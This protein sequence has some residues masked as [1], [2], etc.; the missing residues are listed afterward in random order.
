MDRGHV[1]LTFDHPNSSIY[2]TAFPITDEFGYSALLSVVTDRV[3]PTM[4]DLLGL[5]ELRKLQA[6]GWEIGSHSMTKHPDFMDLST[7][8][9]RRQ[10]QGS[11]EW[12]AKH[13]F[14]T[15][16]PAI[17]YPME[18]VNEAVANITE[19]Y[20]ATGFGG[21]RDLGAPITNPL[22]IGRVNG[23]DVEATRN[24]IDEAAEQNR[25]LSIMYHTVGLDNDRIGTSEFERTLEHIQ[26]KDDLQVITPSTLTQLLAGEPVETPST[27]S[28]EKD[29]KSSQINRTTT[30]QPTTKQ[31]ISTTQTPTSTKTKTTPPK[32]QMGRSTEDFEKKPSATAKTTTPGNGTRTSDTQNGRI[33]TDGPGFGILAALGGL[34]GWITYQLARVEDDK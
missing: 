33:E 29:T 2:N 23:D 30:S 4:G 31:R 18:R 15:E 17:A 3:K 10:C 20:F 9:L 32:V 34:T 24:A 26:A 5:K 12:L 13:G 1:V 11:R 21:P 28:A 8:A 16:A 6:A 19:E 27:D 22:M 7:E 14:E 25:V